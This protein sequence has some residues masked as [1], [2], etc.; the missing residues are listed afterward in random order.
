MKKT[1]FSLLDDWQEVLDRLT[2]E[3]KKD[4]KFIKEAKRIF[5]EKWLTEWDKEHPK[6]NPND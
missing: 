3:E 5:I 4:H 2:P 1:K 6:E